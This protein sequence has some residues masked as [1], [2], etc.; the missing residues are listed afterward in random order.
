[1]ANVLS[2]IEQDFSHCHEI[3][4]QVSKLKIFLNFTLISNVATVADKL[5]I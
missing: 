3:F 4:Y 5:N 2:S 1:M